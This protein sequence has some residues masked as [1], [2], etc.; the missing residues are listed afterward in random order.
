MFYGSVFSLNGHVAI[1][2]DFLGQCGDATDVTVVST[3]TK[4]KSQ[5]ALIELIAGS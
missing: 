2:L 1:S 3:W 4:R 5:A